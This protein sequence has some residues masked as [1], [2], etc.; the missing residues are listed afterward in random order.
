MNAPTPRYQLAVLVILAAI[1][2]AACMDSRPTEPGMVTVPKT[3]RTSVP[4]VASLTMRT[5]SCEATPEGTSA[6]IIGGQNIY[7]K[8]STSNVSYNS[9]T[10]VFS[11]DLTIQ[12]LLNEEMGSPGQ[13]VPDPDG[14]RVFFQSGPTVTGGSGTITVANADGTEALTAPEQ[15]YFAYEEILSK[16]EVSAPRTWQLSIPSTVTSFSF[17]L[18]AEAEIAPKLVINEVM[19]NPSTEVSETNLEWFEV[20]NAGSLRVR[21]DNFVIADSAAS[22]RRPYHLITSSVIIQPGE[23]AVL[24]GSTNTTL[25]GGVTADYEYGGALSL[26]NSLDAIKIARVFGAD[27]ITIDRTQ[28]ANASVSAQ[29]GVS[30]EL[31]NPWLDNSNM[32]GSN[33]GAASVTSVYGAGGRGTP[34]AQNSAYVP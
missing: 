22:G 11:F 10:S 23:Y 7:L 20:Y 8:V 24:A 17:L 34:K 2:L 6:D 31:K 26:A 30:R 25:N 16:D 9:G 21:L 15:P 32:D 14:I 4:C 19:V 13:D 3:L 12:N 33:W 5:V 27:T 18:L 28:Y 29:S 1:G